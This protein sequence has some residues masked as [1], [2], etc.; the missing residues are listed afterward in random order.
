MRLMMTTSLRSATGQ[1]LIVVQDG[2][3]DR[4]PGFKVPKILAETN[5]MDTV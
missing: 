2:D 5:F 1:R 3:L 4:G